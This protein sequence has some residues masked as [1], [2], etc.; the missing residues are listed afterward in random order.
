L[1]VPVVQENNV[2][3]LLPECPVRPQRQQTKGLHVPV[4]VVCHVTLASS[5]IDTLSS[6]L[7]MGL[8]Q[9]VSARHAYEGSLSSLQLVEAEKAIKRNLPQTQTDPAPLTKHE[10]IC[11]PLSLLCLCAGFSI[12]SSD[13][14]GQGTPSDDPAIST[15]P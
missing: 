8:K 11:P 12:E 15:P 13:S 10:P 3:V 1:Y 9:Q 14:F 6:S 2:A 7:V 5:G 4:I